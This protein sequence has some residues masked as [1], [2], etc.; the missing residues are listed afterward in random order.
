MTTKR[1]HVKKHPQYFWAEVNPKG[2]IVVDIND[3]IYDGPS[4]SFTRNGIY[5]EAGNKIIKVRFIAV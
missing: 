2:K 4:I 1:K 3:H 5:A